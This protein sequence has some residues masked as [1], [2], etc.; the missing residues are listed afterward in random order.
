V[1]PF[2]PQFST[3]TTRAAAKIDVGHIR[4]AVLDEVGHHA[5]ERRLHYTEM[6]RD[7]VGSDQLRWGSRRLAK[8]AS[9][10]KRF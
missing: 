5:G 7:A 6:A 1:Q 3:A 10:P 8:L 9:A 4:I 2:R